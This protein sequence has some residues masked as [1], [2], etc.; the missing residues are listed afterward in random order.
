MIIIAFILVVISDTTL[1]GQ[2]TAGR[3]K[4]FITGLRLH[5]GYIFAHTKSIEA[6][7]HSNPLGIQ[8]DFNWHFTSTNAYNYCNCYP[9]LGLSF[10]YWDFRNPTI[11]GKAV[12]ILAF[13]EPFFR[14]KKKLSF[15][16]RPGMGIS[17]LNNPYDEVTNPENLC[18]ST[19]FA[20]ALLINI[21][22]YYKITDHLQVNLVGNYNHISNGGINIPNKGLNYPSVSLGLDY[23]FHPIQFAKQ[24]KTKGSDFQRSYFIRTAILIGFKGLTED[25]KLYFITGLLGK[26][27]WRFTQMSAITGGTEFIMDGAEK[28]LMTIYPE[29]P[30]SAPY[31]LSLTG[32]YE[33]LLGKFSL[34]FDL[35]IYLV[36][37]NRRTDLIY[38]RYGVVYKIRDKVCF[39]LN[40]KAHQHV[41]DFFDIRLGFMF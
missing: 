24:E 10:Y 34:T 38:Q 9:R 16:I 4:Y 18:Y 28:Q 17:Y 11:L 1:L 14:S 5:Y 31:K 35:G 7:A 15:S 27:G 32:G 8:A 36:N 41:A 40:L 30:S 19:Q 6:A 21:S 12:N 20:F 22:A 3:D 23:N 33:Y 2:S 37:T 39:G 26:F 25:D 13:A 29:I